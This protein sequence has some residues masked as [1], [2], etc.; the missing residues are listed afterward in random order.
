MAECGSANCFRKRARR[1]AGSSVDQKKMFPD[2]VYQGGWSGFLFFQSDYIFSSDFFDIVIEFMRIENACS[3][4]LINIDKKEVSES[5]CAEFF[6]ERNSL[7]ESYARK[8]VG[9]GRGDGWLYEF[10]RYVCSTD[11]G[12]WAIYCE[13]SNDIAVIA[14]RE[15]GLENKF[16][17]V[18]PLLSASPINLLVDGEVNLSPFNE[19][20]PTWKRGLRENY[21]RSRQGK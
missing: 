7:S 18:L 17:E 6:F 15:P 16:R 19:L 4:A 5:E 2:Q 21:G 3:A 10:D 12:S 11:V 8:L 14:F 20:V 13:K 9:E 1:N